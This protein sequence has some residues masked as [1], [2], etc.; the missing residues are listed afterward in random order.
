M[1]ELFARITVN[2]SVESEQTMCFCIQPINET[3]IISLI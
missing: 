2:G 3:N 1:V